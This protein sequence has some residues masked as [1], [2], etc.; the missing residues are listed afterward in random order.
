LLLDEGVILSGYIGQPE[1]G[2]VDA[3]VV[4]SEQGQQ[5]KAEAISEERRQQ[6]GGINTRVKPVFPA[7]AGCFLSGDAQKRSDYQEIASS[8]CYRDPQ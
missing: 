2:L 7:I 8:R 6:V 4:L 3:R 5:V 1:Q